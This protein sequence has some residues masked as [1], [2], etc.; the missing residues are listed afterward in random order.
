ME[1]ATNVK[2]L[3]VLGRGDPRRL[4]D[5]DIVRRFVI[6]LVRKVGMEPLGEPVIHDVP[7]EVAKLGREPFQDEGGI[8][9]Q[10]VGFH[11]LSTSHV[12]IHTWPLR[13][14]FHLDLY[15]CRE[16]SKVEV[17]AFIQEIFHT[18]RMVSSDLTFACEW[19]SYD[20]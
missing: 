19:E 5:A 7:L 2:H 1:T 20:S 16:F 11:T 15:S 8:T 4:G 6:D 14:E 17:G 13:E 18:T 10:L 3:K 12:A 9:A